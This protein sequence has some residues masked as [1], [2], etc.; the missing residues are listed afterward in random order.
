MNTSE[1]QDNHEEIFHQHYMYVDV[2]SSSKC[3]DEPRDKGI[4]VVLKK[5]FFTI[6]L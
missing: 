3:V 5:Q 1:L 4:Y 2:C 6:F